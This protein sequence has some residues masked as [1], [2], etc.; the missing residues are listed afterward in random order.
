MR[1]LF[2]TIQGFES[3]FYG[4]VG[5]RLEALGNEV[6]HLTYSR[7]AARLLREGGR[8]AQALAEVDAPAVVDA[9][10]ELPR[11][12]RGLGLASIR[13]LYR[14]DPAAPRNGEATNIRRALDHVRRIEAVFDRVQP[15]VLVPEVGNEL[16]RVAAHEIA[17]ARGVPTLFLFYTIFPRPLRL[18]VNAM[19]APIVEPAE[20]RPLTAEEEWELDEF[21]AEYI[22]RQG[23]IRPHRRAHI[24]R[25]Q[26]RRLAMYLR[27]WS[28]EDSSNEYLNPGHW[29]AQHAAERGRRIPARLLYDTLVPNRKFVYFPLHVTDDYKIRRLIPHCANQEALID[30]VADSL[31]AG[32]DLV[33]KEHPM[34][35]GRN[36]IG[37]LR[38][39]K[40]LPNVRLVDPHSSTHELIQSASAIAVIGSTVGLEALLYER[41][42]LT[43]GRPFYSGYG[44][45]VDIDSFAEIPT[46]M[47]QLLGFT[48]DREQT[49]RFLHAAMRRCQPGAPVLVDDSDANADAL[50]ASLDAAASNVAQRQPATATSSGAPN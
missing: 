7:R 5:D 1:F 17:L 37:F 30:L 28:G 39:L 34:S 46:A 4:R 20:L 2:V 25:Q 49:R 26:V 14:T 42:V 24:T 48:P 8:A 35:I 29:L 15:D 36:P 23:M 3:E 43:L 10:A 16:L 31:P 33:V 19:H 12:E 21:R 32:Y 6:T 50:A 47:N 18:Y 13:D 40:H 38:R 45:T 22:S 9:D 41:P 11:I 44:I 27:A